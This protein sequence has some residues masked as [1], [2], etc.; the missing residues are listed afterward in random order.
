MGQRKAMNVQ[1]GYISKPR[2]RH[3]RIISLKENLKRRVV[4]EVK[5][6]SGDVFT[7]P[8]KQL[9]NA[10]NDIHGLLTKDKLRMHVYPP[11]M[12][13]L[14]KVQTNLEDRIAETFPSGKAGLVYLALSLGVSLDLD[15]RMK[16]PHEVM[17]DACVI[18][19]NGAPMVLTVVKGDAKKTNAISKYNLYVAKALI[20]AVRKFTNENF[21]ALHGVLTA[22]DMSSS[23]KFSKAY[24]S[25]DKESSCFCIPESLSM[26]DVKY[27]SI[28][29]AFAAVASSTKVVQILSSENTGVTQTWFLTQE[30]FVA[31][32]ENIDKNVVIV[33]AES[34][35]GSTTL[36]LEVASRLERSGCTLLVS[37]S[38]DLCK[39]VR[40]HKLCSRVMVANTFHKHM[41]QHKTLPARVKHVVCEGNWS[42]ET[43]C[44][45][46]VWCFLVK[47]ETDRS[48]VQD[49]ACPETPPCSP[50]QAC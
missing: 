3:K 20:R 47:R 29:K 39:T 23:E 8:L 13:D 19:T 12:A 24:V 21:N 6:P 42:P 38:P 10:L 9:G 1:N 44:G 37:S 7:R 48:P 11:Y 31:L 14:S 30:Q 33:G 18:P 34:G 43:D 28:T 45:G 16:Q 27:A 22:D 32:S 49:F 26:S 50:I 36:M 41:S 46:R 25:I 15:V 4:N 17:F 35:T 2:R 40:K 5:L